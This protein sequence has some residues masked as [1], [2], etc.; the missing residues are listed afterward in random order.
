M[1]RDGTWY[2]ASLDVS[3]EQTQR[4]AQLDAS[5]MFEHQS[6]YEA[7]I[8]MDWNIEECAAS[9]AEEFEEKCQE[10]R[11]NEMFSKAMASTLHHNPL[12]DVMRNTRLCSG[13]GNILRYFH[14]REMFRRTIERSIGRHRDRIVTMMCFPDSPGYTGDGRFLHV[15]IQDMHI[16][17]NESVIRVRERHQVSVYELS[18]SFS[19]GR[20]VLNAPRQQKNGQ[21]YTMHGVCDAK[22]NVPLLFALTNKKTEAIYFIIWSTLKGVLDRVAQRNDY[23]LRKVVDSEKASIN[24]LRRAP[25][26]EQRLMHKDLRRRRK[27]CEMMDNF[28]RLM[29]ER[30]YAYLFGKGQ[31]SQIRTTAS[32]EADALNMVPETRWYSRKSRDIGRG[33]KAVLCGSPRTTS[34]VGIIVSERFRD[35][36]VSVERFDVD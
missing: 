20:N 30:W 33:F 22:V 6:V 2:M 15:Q 5:E 1:L 17:Y 9:E 28:E 14:D 29:Q 8:Q 12:R 4:L 26:A 25:A 3:E 18:G 34:G 11:F 19:S 32:A 7:T 23:T 16:Y 24:R 13:G 27:V 31:R 21:L 10:W 36:I 35:S